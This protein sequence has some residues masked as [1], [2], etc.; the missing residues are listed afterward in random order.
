METDM[1]ATFKFDQKWF[2]ET[3]LEKYLGF[4]PST[5]TNAADIP[6]M[7]S[8]TGRFKTID[9]STGTEM[10]DEFEVVINSSLETPTDLCQTA[11]TA[12]A[13]EDG[14]AMTV[15]RDYEVTD[16]NKVKSIYIP[17]TLTGIDTIGACRHQIHKTLDYVLPSG[18][19]KTAWSER[20]DH[21]GHG[22]QEWSFWIEELEGFD[23]LMV[24]VSH[25]DYVNK[26]QMM[27]KTIDASISATMMISYRNTLGEVILSNS[28]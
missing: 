8:V 28:F 13:F 1:K 12:L 22:T 15:P 20:G 9:D 26:G 24:R 19:V 21:E 5:V 23:H 10:F 25:E 17:T 3:G 6:G 18:L 4:D 14:T 16:E 2:L 7:L 11:F 27:Y